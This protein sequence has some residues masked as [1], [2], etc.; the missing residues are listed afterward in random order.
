MNSNEFID[1]IREKFYIADIVE[2]YEIP[3]NEL[4]VEHKKNKNEDIESFVLGYIEN[5]LKKDNKFV[6]RIDYYYA[7]CEIGEILYF[8]NKKKYNKEINDSYNIGRPIS[9][10]I[11]K[12]KENKM[13]LER[14]LF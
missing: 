9:S 13:E 6:G 4:I 12:N 8:F 7:S 11:I 3:I 5:I 10:R 1:K 2:Y 14:S